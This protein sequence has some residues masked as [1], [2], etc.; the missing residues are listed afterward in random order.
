MYNYHMT[1]QTHNPS[2]PERMFLTLLFL[3]FVSVEKQIR[4]LCELS[5]TQLQ[6]FV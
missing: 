2:P 1:S 5:A 6:P 4:G 3:F